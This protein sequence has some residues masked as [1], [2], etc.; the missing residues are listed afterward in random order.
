MAESAIIYWS[1]K[2]AIAW[3]QSRDLSLVEQASKVRGKLV[4]LV[5]LAQ[6][7]A[8]AKGRDVNA[9]LWRAS[10]WMPSSDTERGFYVA[11]AVIRKRP[12][13]FRTVAVVESKDRLPRFPIEECL[14]ALFRAGRLTSIGRRPAPHEGGYDAL[15][16]AEWNE[17]EIRYRGDI[18]VAEST[19]PFENGTYYYVQVPRSDV[20]REFPAE[21]PAKPPPTDEEIKTVI[22]AE[23]KRLGKRL[24]RHDGPYGGPKK[25]KEIMK[26]TY[27]HRSEASAFRIRKLIE[28]MHPKPNRGPQGPR[29]KL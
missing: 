20:M 4:E 25:V 17:L 11:E 19:L 13:K 27:P 9:E 3:A 14:T 23:E 8:K 28:L 18:P 1:L 5:A 29:K 7:R 12:T 15:Q 26:E 2:Q 21:A 10:G 16:P 24:P 6:V 22:Q